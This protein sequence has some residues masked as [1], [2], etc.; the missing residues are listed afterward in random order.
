[1]GHIYRG[2]HSHGDAQNGLFHGKSQIKMDDLGE[3]P[4]LG[5]FKSSING[6]LNGNKSFVN[7]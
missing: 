3:N 2:F 4:I 5:N 7:G 6:S 1:M